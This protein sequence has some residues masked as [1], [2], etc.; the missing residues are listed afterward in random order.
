MQYAA[1]TQEIPPKTLNMPGEPRTVH[2]VPLS[3]SRNG[4]GPPGA[5]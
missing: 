5:A 1:E 4:D 3:V 2:F